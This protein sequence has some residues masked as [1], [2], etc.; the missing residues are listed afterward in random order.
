MEILNDQMPLLDT[1]PYAKS[2]V[3]FVSAVPPSLRLLKESL[4]WT[5]TVS[6]D[7]GAVDTL[8]KLFA[9]A[10]IDVQVSPR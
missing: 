9:R 1:A 2:V 6:A 8:K 7:S 10:K 5:A 4:L 3:P